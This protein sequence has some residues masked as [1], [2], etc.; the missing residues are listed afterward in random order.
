[1][2]LVAFILEV[3][4]VADTP[5]VPGAVPLAPPPPGAPPP[6]PPPPVPGINAQIKTQK[7]VAPTKPQ[8][9]PRVK[10]RPLFWNRI[11]IDQCYDDDGRFTFP[12]SKILI[13]N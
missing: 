6:P 12:L 9:L 3:T 7:S 8:V 2:H 11:L 5:Q 1:M 13:F 10:M 4:S